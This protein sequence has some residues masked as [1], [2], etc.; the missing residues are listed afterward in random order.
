MGKYLG[1]KKWGHYEF[2]DISGGSA[3]RERRP[4]EARGPAEALNTET[5][6]A[7]EIISK[8]FRLAEPARVAREVLSKRSGVSAN[9]STLHQ[10]DSGSDWRD[11]RNERL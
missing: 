4:P 5:D 6:Q 10:H 7:C 9:R 8:S 2:S 1:K 11:R 3:W